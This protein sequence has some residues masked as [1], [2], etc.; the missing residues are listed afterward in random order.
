MEKANYKLALDGGWQ[1]HKGDFERAKSMSLSAYHTA[2]Q[3]GG[4]FCGLLGF[5]ND[6]SWENI[7]VPHD[8]L[9]H[10]PY[11]EA[12]DSSGGYKARGEAWYRNK[13]TLPNMAIESAQLVFEG[14]LGQCVVYVNGVLAGRNFSGY[15]A[16]AFEIGDYLLPGKENVVHVYVDARK[17]EGWWYE[18]NGLYRPVGIVFR[19]GARLDKGACFV[20]G[21]RL[22]G[23]WCAVLDFAVLNAEKSKNAQ[24][25]ISLTDEKG[26]LISEQ[27]LGVEVTHVEISVQDAA[28]WSPEQPTLYHA[29]IALVCDGETLDTAHYNVGFRSIEWRAGEGMFLNGK[30]YQVKGICGHQDH[31]GMGAAVTPEVMEYRVR[32]MKSL[33]ANAYRCAHHAVTEQFLSLCDEYGLLV[34]A[35]NRRFAVSD[36]VLGELADMVKLS[37]NHPSV[38]LYSMFNEEPWQQDFRGKRMAAKMRQCVRSLDTT[39]AVMAAQNGGM[40]EKENASDSFDIIGLNYNLQSYDEAF[41]RTPDK[42]ILGT[43]NCPTYATR[44]VVK[45]DVEKQVFADNGREYPNKFSED[46]EETMVKI[47]ASKYAAGCFVWTGMDHRG[48]PHPYGWPSVSSHWGFTDSCGFDKEIAYLLRAW[49]TDEPFVHVLKNWNHTIGEDVC[50]HVFTNVDEVELFINGRSLG[51]KAVINRRAEWQVPFEQGVLRAVGVKGAM[52]VCDESYTAGEAARL[53]L[54]NVT[55]GKGEFSKIVN[56]KVVDVQGVLVPDFCQEIQFT[57]D[58]GNV[59]GVGNGNPNSHYQDIALQVPAFNGLAQIVVTGDTKGLTVAC[60]GLPSAQI[61]MG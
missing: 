31:A 44:G 24:V 3:A 48:E 30:R 38:F 12:Y 43:E 40:L 50:V 49:N 33:H 28:L 60:A 47:N 52:Q 58:D 61:R 15:N 2:S 7:C 39:R 22:H 45:T 13:F 19:K 25:C 54:E 32:V 23:A 6:E 16:F 4:L 41:K 34:M 8:W 29:A 57:L 36:E 10:Q 1:F 21:E 55:P 11:D 53:V 56:V 27:V 51:R 42:V 14:V 26:A 17:A 20:R 9:A 35:E 18:G 37:R 59:L 5:F 46:I